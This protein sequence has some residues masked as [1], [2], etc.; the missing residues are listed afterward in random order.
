M[1]KRI[2]CVVLAILMI[3]T[4]SMNVFAVRHAK[5]ANAARG[6]AI[7]DAKFDDAYL[8]ADKLLVNQMA[9]GEGGGGNEAH[10]EAW[11]LWDDVALYFFLKVYDDTPSGNPVKG[12][13]WYNDAVD[14]AFDFDNLYDTD[15]QYGDNGGMFKISPYAEADDPVYTHTG[16]PYCVWLEDK[17][18]HAVDVYPG[19][20][21]I[22][23]KFPYNDE[24]KAMAKEGA[25]IGLDITICD[26]IN[27]AEIR[28][29]TAHWADD[30]VDAGN[31]WGYPW[32]LDRL[33]LS[34]ATYV[35]P[36][37]AP[38]PVEDVPAPANDAPAATTT[39]AAP[40]AKTGDAGIIALVAV[41]ALAA[42]VVVFKR[43][44]VK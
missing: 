14:F 12:T 19:G 34:G 44:A 9:D 18:E 26:C 13:W 11:V 29:G 39:T 4:L 16:F 6:T 5:S 20:Y 25:Y 43:K 33:V 38:A 42:G 17:I 1:K 32:A 35:A 37:E 40:A 15:D 8:A 28:A 24:M 2:I 41:M 23:V 7:I 27:D 36:T 30:P 3:M 21:T 31:N 10:G 22:E